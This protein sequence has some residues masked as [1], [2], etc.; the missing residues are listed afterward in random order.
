MSDKQYFTKERL[1]ELKKEFENLK[2][3]K[4]IEVGER[5][6]R[7]KELGDLSEN[8]E[9]FEAREEQAQVETRILELEEMIKH[10]AIIEKVHAAVVVSVGSTVVAEK[11][12]QQMKFTIV[13]SNEA[14]P[15]AGLI[16][17]ESPLGSAF[18]GKKSGDKVVVATPGG[19]VE[20]LIISIE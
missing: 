20:Y 5:L 1:E 6:R 11:N 9:Y 8:S 7:A 13:G 14:Q 10:A 12:G 2:T 4:R 19:K 3:Q 16:S 17:N 15:E 18:L